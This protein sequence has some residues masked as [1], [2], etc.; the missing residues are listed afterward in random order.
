MI[1]TPRQKA[2]DTRAAH[3]P[4][5]PILSFDLAAEAEALRREARGSGGHGARTLVKDAGLRIVLL[6]LEAGARIHEHK[7]DHRISVQTLSGRV[8][9]QLPGEAIDLPAGKLLVLDE[10][11]AHDVVARED[12]VVLL[13]MSWAT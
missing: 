12:S 9:L 4:A 2:R 13:S 5:G 11:I 7:T 1:E 6:V 3:V 8:G 10:G